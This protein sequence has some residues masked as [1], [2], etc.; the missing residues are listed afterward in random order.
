MTW[1]LGL[2]GMRSSEK[3]VL[4]C[5]CNYA[6][7][8]GTCYPSV[9]QLAADTCQDRKTVLANMESLRAAGMIS[10]TGKRIGKTHGVVVYRVNVSNSTEN[11]TTDQKT[12]SSEIGT[13][14]EI[15]TAEAVPFFRG[16][17]TVFPRKRSQKRDMDP[18]GTVRN[19]KSAPRTACRLPD[20][21]QLTQERRL[22]AEAE[23]LPADRTFAKF[24]NYW[25]AASGAKA[26]KA[27]WDATWKNWCMNEADRSPQAAKPK[28]DNYRNAI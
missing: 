10:D 23:R 12:S 5:M 8:D 9:A 15:G 17:G 26:R 18:K 24:V 4:V 3:F 20:D 22:V 1:A 13:G 14:T 27:D 16:S 25:R 11:G 19:Q 28:P 7:E 2:T 6:N 21:F